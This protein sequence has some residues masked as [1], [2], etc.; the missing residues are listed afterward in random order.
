MSPVLGLS[1]K[2]QVRIS[3]GICLYKLFHQFMHSFLE[4]F[5]IVSFGKHKIRV[6]VVPIGLSL[7]HQKQLLVSI[8]LT[9]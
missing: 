5:G 1:L 9:E 7:D 8:I 2:F 4:I 3:L 6:Y